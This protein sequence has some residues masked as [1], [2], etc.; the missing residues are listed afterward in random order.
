MR[1]ALIA[2]GHGRVGDSTIRGIIR[3]QIEQHEPHLAHL[4]GALPMAAGQNP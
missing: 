1:A 3:A 4:P 2:A